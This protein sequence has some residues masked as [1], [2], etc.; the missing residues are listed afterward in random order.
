MANVD[1]F[2]EARS[3][4]H[5]NKPKEALVHIDR[6]VYADEYL[7]SWIHYFNSDQFKDVWGQMPPKGLSNS[8]EISK[9]GKF[10][11]FIKIAGSITETTW[12]IKG[13]TNLTKLFISDVQKLFLKEVIDESNTDLKVLGIMKSSVSFFPYCPSVTKLY[14]SS[15]TL[16]TQPELVK[17]LNKSFPNLKLLS[18]GPFSNH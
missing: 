17:L 6:I 18:F 11:P 3:L 15:N 4:L 5:A 16:L 12:P 9:Y 2:N 7:N 10:Y 1:D 13:V 8:Y 14:F